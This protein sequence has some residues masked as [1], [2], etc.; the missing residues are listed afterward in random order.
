LFSL[1]GRHSTVRFDSISPNS[2]Y[3]AV[4]ISAHNEFVAYS[5]GVSPDYDGAYVDLRYK[6]GGNPKPVRFPGEGTLLYFNFDSSGTALYYIREQEN[7][8]RDCYYLDLS[9][10]VAQAP[11][12]VNRDGRTRHCISQ[13]LPP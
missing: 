1:S 11:V 8:A 13:P 4:E 9:R 6:T 7:G 12:K 3:R 5:K 2:E 10:Q